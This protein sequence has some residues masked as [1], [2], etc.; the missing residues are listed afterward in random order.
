MYM[1]ANLTVSVHAT[2]LYEVENYTFQV[3]STLSRANAEW[4]PLQENLR[5]SDTVAVT[6]HAR[7][8]VSNHTQLIFC[9]T[10]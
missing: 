1:S 3:N 5:A 7:H 2:L 8:D 4:T 10:D 6:S 9:W